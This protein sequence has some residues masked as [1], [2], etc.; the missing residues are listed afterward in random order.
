M[1]TSLHS[2]IKESESSN[3]YTHLLKDQKYS[4]AGIK[5]FLILCLEQLEGFIECLFHLLPTTQRLLDTF[6]Q[7]NL[8][9]RS[10]LPIEEPLPPRG[11]EI[12]VEGLGETDR[13][14]MDVIKKKERKCFPTSAPNVSLL[15]RHRKKTQER[16]G[17]G[18][19]SG[20]VML[21]AVTTKPL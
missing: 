10:R 20:P 13:H 5:S 18:A 17:G 4:A 14:P 16:R 19:K 11:D 6:N 2:T 3:D 7:A 21:G 9:H 15:C 8:T 12:H 1:K